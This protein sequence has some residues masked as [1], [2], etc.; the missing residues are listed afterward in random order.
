MMLSPVDGR[1]VREAQPLGRR[2]KRSRW[3]R[4]HPNGSAETPLVRRV[5]ATRSCVLEESRYWLPTWD[6]IIS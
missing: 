1:H 5:S 4:T 2:A 3:K 6:A